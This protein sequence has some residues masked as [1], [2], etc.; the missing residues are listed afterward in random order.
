M[1]AQ[2][3]M[4][5][6]LLFAGAA[7]L[8][9]GGLALWRAVQRAEAPPAVPPT[10]LPGAA[11]PG[12]VSTG[13]AA[14]P[15]I[16]PLAAGPS[17]AA[18]LL[19]DGELEGAVNRFGQTAMGQPYSW[20]AGGP[21]APW[22]RG[23]AGERGG[24]GWDCSGLVAAAWAGL[25]LMP[26]SGPRFWTGSVEALCDA[27]PL[28]AQRPG[29][30]VLY[31]GHIVLVLTWADAKGD[32]LVLSAGG[33]GRDTNGDDPGAQVKVWSSWRY[34]GDAKVALRP[35]PSLAV[36]ISEGQREACL[37]LHA[38]LAGQGLPAGS[39]LAPGRRDELLR[40]FYGEID[41]VR[42]TLGGAA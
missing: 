2:A 36:Q 38:L 1:A 41:V 22:P 42:A 25:L 16:S 32:S 15:G 8:G 9:L 5:P 39:G 35:K 26:W 28:G 40:Q 18:Y 37:S 11:S 19:T 24:R 33:G 31:D 13:R 4:T 30:A 6:L 20:G 7:T 12:G 34:R 27:V 21:G 17:A 14:A 29:D 23:S 3:D 10:V